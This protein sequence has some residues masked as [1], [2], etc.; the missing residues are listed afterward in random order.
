LDKIKEHGED[1]QSDKRADI[2]GPLPGS[3]VNSMDLGLQVFGRRGGNRFYRLF[4]R[5]LFLKK[6]IRSLTKRRGWRSVSMGGVRRVVQYTAAVYNC[7]LNISDGQL[8]V[9]IVNKC[10]ANRIQTIEKDA[11]VRD[12]LGTVNFGLNS[13][14]FFERTGRVLRL[15]HATPFAIIKYCPGF[16]LARRL[17]TR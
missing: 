14:E 3:R 17:V 9:E 10:P 15:V 1:D 13:S 12:R 4:S 2:S 5:G 7:L 8:D 16:Y 6:D 11:E